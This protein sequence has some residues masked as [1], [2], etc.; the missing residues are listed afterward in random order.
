MLT[1]FLDLGVK[2]VAVEDGVVVE[3]GDSLAGD[4]TIDASGLTVLP[5]FVDTHFHGYA[6]VDFTL[7]SP[8]DVLRVSREVVKHGV[9]GFLASFV[10]A[11]RETL[12]KACRSVAEAAK[13]WKPGSGAR[14]L[15]VH[16]EG[17]FLNPRMKGAMD[18]RFLRNPS[19]EEFSEYY[20]AS[21]GLVRQV[22]VAPELP[23]A[24]DFV[25]RVAAQG[26]VVSIGHTEATYDEVVRAVAAGASKANHVFNQMR[27]FHH[28]EPGAAF[29]LLEMPNVYVEA[30]VDFVHL[31]PA[32]VR[33]VAQLAGPGRLALV[34]DAV[35]ATG[36]PDGTYSLGGLTIV[37]KGGVSR[38]AD[39]GALAGSTLTMDR[40]FSNMVKLGYSVADA[41]R[42]ASTTPAAS[43]GLG[44]RV[45]V[46]APGYQADLVLVDEKL[47]VVK[48]I[49]GGVEVYGG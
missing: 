24:V 37:V 29:A 45:G 26:V 36:L 47:R 27:Q 1:P 2:D 32:T 48:T 21:E 38:L 8:E 49:V 19:V 25:R 43:V 7:A 17:P 28:R 23:G 12:L 46:V 22:T 3:V 39:T 18:E 6:G 41:A 34:T 11:P 33:L 16:L 40:A 5:G 13:A 10:A 14:I 31:H 42:M 4:K 30:I 20:R 15:G 9:T 35:A 44:G